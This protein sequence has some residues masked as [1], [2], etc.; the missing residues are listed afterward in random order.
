MRNRTWS[1]SRATPLWFRNGGVMRD[2]RHICILLLAFSLPPF[3]AAQE[4]PENKPASPDAAIGATDSKPAAAAPTMSDSSALTGAQSLTLGD[5]GR[6]VH[7][8]LQPTFS[9]SQA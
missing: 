3:M 7:N 9:F 1:C 8:F 6:R 4:S 2:V 5:G